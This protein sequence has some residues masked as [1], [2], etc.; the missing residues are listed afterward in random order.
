[1]ATRI[2]INGSEITNPFIRA[3]LILGMILVTALVTAAVIFVLLPLIGIAVSLTVS[4]ILI[5]IV[6]VIVSGVALALMTLIS[7]W[8]FGTSEFRIE[9][10]HKRK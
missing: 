4:F 2:I 5:I 10:I 7:S 9:R 3:L 1:M 6:A 8:L